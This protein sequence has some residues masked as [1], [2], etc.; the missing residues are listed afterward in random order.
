MC[1]MHSN[2][3]KRSPLASTVDFFRA[4]TS[5]AMRMPYMQPL[6]W[7]WMW[8]IINRPG[9]SI[10]EIAAACA[11]RFVPPLDESTNLGGAIMLAP[12]LIDQ[13]MVV[14]GTGESIHLQRVYQNQ[15]GYDDGNPLEVDSLP[16]VML[17]VVNT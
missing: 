15:L 9:E 2:T 13:T 12:M 11:A 16:A 7:K 10:I 1:F 5:D 8:S 3:A 6:Y 4:R 17:E 14:G